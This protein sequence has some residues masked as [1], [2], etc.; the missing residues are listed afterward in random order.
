MKIIIEDIKLSYKFYPGMY[1]KSIQNTYMEY[2]MK[3][4]NKFDYKTVSK[5]YFEKYINQVIPDKY[6]K[7]KRILNDYWIN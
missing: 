5:N 2:C 4:K 7:K 6:I 3:A 1:E